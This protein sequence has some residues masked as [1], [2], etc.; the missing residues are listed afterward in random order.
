[1]AR[2]HDILGTLR[3]A[4]SFAPRERN[5]IKLIFT[6]PDAEQTRWKL[7]ARGVKIL[8]RPW[9][10]CDVVDPE[11]NIFGLTQSTS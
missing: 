3:P 7:E 9:G 5:P 11:G 4:A 10:G 1:M 8:I 2:S 6:V